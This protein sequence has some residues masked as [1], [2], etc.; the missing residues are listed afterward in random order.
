MV[1]E[2]LVNGN[3]EIFV[4]RFLSW[5]LRFEGTENE[6]KAQ[7]IRLGLDLFFD[8]KDVKIFIPL[9]NTTIEDISQSKNFYNDAKKI[10]DIKLYYVYIYNLLSR[11][12]SLNLIKEDTEFIKSLVAEYESFPDDIIVY[13]L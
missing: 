6:K 13:Y 4:Y 1:K 11:S 10:K 5:V 3:N 8:W 7:F 2:F 9:V 12:S